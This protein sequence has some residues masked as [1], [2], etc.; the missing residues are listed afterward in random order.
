MNWGQMI[1]G[2][3]IAVILLA[4]VIVVGGTI[5]EG[6][7]THNERISFNELCAEHEMVYKREYNACVNHEGALYDPRVWLDDD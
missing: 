2:S 3:L 5:A 4:L 6:V 1:F 7:D